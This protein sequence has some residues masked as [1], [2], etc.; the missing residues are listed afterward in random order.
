MSLLPE[1]LQ[2]RFPQIRSMF[3]V[4]TV[5]IKEARFEIPYVFKYG[6]V[7]CID[8]PKEATW[9]VVFENLRRAIPIPMNYELWIENFYKKGDHLLKVDEVFECSVKKTIWEASRVET[10]A[11]A[12][13]GEI[14]TDRREMV[15]DV[16][17]L[18]R[19]TREAYKYPIPGVENEV[20]E[21][22]PPPPHIK[23]V[24]MKLLDH[25]ISWDLSNV[26][27]HTPYYYKV[28]GSLVVF[29][30]HYKLKNIVSGEVG[31]DLLSPH[32]YVLHDDGKS[33]SHYGKEAVRTKIAQG[34][35][36]AQ[37]LSENIIAE[38][39]G[40]VYAQYGFHARYSTY[41]KIKVFGTTFKIY[42]T[43]NHI[44]VW[45]QELN[46]GNIILP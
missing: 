16:A 18:Q 6:E 45:T 26:I 9:T 37:S 21:D 5:G 7:F 19:K 25:E 3:D 12:K 34:Q 14:I 31:V 15:F 11:Y 2:G 10:K 33:V 44:E 23:K 38:A 8:P 1:F 24:E 4:Q 35:S 17:T 13:V 29:T 40:K 22:F 20:M 36:L 42:I 28:P 32:I 41:K 27:E 30:V 43:V 39:Y 46:V